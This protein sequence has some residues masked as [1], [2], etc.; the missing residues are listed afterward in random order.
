MMSYR[1]NTGTILLFNNASEL[2]EA[3]RE[4]SLIKS[5]FASETSEAIFANFGWRITNISLQFV[6]YLL[7]S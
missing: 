7:V 4:A 2:H 3:T 6:D 5:Q 1:T